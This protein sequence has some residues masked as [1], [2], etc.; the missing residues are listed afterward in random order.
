[1]AKRPEISPWPNFYQNC[2]SRA[3][4]RKNYSSLAS[5]SS[6]SNSKHTHKK[7]NKKRRALFCA[8]FFVR[9]EYYWSEFQ[10]GYF[11]VCAAF[12]CCWVFWKIEIFKIGAYQQA[13]GVPSRCHKQKCKI[14]E[15]KREL[16]LGQILH[17]T[18]KWSISYG[19]HNDLQ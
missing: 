10:I 2:W 12:H 1:M 9:W 15:P 19:A 3:N 6:F 5:F 16:W 18:A 7:A 13:K 4:G 14:E 8:G 11:C 17:D